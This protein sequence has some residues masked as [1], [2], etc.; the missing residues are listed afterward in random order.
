[1][2]Y[3]RIQDEKDQFRERAYMRM[4]TK[5]IEANGTL[6]DWATDVAMRNQAQMEAE[7]SVRGLYLE[8]LTAQITEQELEL[9]EQEA[10]LTEELAMQNPQAWADF[11]L[12]TDLPDDRETFLDALEIWADK[13]T[14][15][16]MVA[17]TRLMLADYHGLPRPTEPGTLAD[18]W[19]PEIQPVH[20]EMDRQLAG[21]EERMRQARERR[22]KNQQP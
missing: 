16:L 19:A 14:T 12:R 6:P 20:E 4:K 21:I 2:L 15:W 22:L 9:E 1:M 11:D 7:N 17:G 3:T 13:P 10:E 18:Q 5:H 8:P